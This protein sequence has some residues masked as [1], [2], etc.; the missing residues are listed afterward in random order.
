MRQRVSGFAS[1]GLLT[2]Q[3]KL[4]WAAEPGSREVGTIPWYAP[5]HCL[6]D[7]VVYTLVRSFRGAADV[8]ARP[9]HAEDLPV[10]PLR[11]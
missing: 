4:G 6:N 3:R 5:E 2:A 11:E 8:L 10:R 1:V 9:V 7:L